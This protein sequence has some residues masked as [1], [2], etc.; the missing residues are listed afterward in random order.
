MT[1]PRIRWRNLYLMLNAQAAV[2]I[3][4]Q[5]YQDGFTRTFL[6]QCAAFAPCVYDR[7]GGIPGAEIAWNLADEGQKIAGFIGGNTAAFGTWVQ[8]QCLQFQPCF[9]DVIGIDEFIKQVPLPDQMTLLFGTY[10][11]AGGAFIERSLSKSN[12]TFAK[13]ALDNLTASVPPSQQNVEDAM[14]FLVQAGFDLTFMDAYLNQINGTT[15]EK[16][17]KPIVEQ[18][19]KSVCAAQQEKNVKKETCLQILPLAQALQQNPANA[20]SALPAIAASLIQGG[21]NVTTFEAYTVSKNMNQAGPQAFYNIRNTT[22]AAAAEQQVTKSVCESAVVT[23]AKSLAESNAT[24]KRQLQEQ[25]I[26]VMAQPGGFSLNTFAPNL[27]TGYMNTLIV[28]TQGAARVT[29]A[30]KPFIIPY[31]DRPSYKGMNASEIA[32]HMR[33]CPFWT[34]QLPPPSVQLAVGSTTP[35]NDFDTFTE[36]G[37]LELIYVSRG[38][39][40]FFEYGWESCKWTITKIN[41]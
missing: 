39:K 18:F 27:P 7:V 24:I 33:R 30:L 3:V 19:S 22:C 34:T 12:N 15:A 16:V 5:T 8:D 35:K 26:G 36:A 38:W 37:A 13:A 28:F 40:D 9:V 4:A 14:G 31:G 25:L 2:G 41:K 20:A 10:Q 6:D 11:L 1:I 23:Y 29:P 17:I 32:K 21:Y